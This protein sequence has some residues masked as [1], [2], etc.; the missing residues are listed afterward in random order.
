MS[1]LSPNF[2]SF[3]LCFFSAG[4]KNL[5]FAPLITINTVSDPVC[6]SCTQLFTLP[7]PSKALLE[8]L[9]I[10]YH[11]FVKSSSTFQFRQNVIL[12]IVC[13][14]VFLVLLLA[15]GRILLREG[16]YRSFQILREYMRNHW[17]TMEISG[18]A[19]GEG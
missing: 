15:S 17:T 3:H 1:V 19:A 9:K 2:N 12:H 10:L 14:N 6:S 18:S 11:N 13:K 4:L 7:P 5:Y 8:F 16:P